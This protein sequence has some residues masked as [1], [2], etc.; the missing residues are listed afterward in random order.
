MLIRRASDIPSAEDIGL[1]GSKYV[2]FHQWHM[3]VCGGV[4]QNGRT[5]TLHDAIKR[6]WGIDC[7]DLSMK[8]EV[9][10][11]LRHL[12]VKIEERGF[13]LVE[14]DESAG[15]KSRHLSADFGAY[16]TRGARYHDNPSLDAFAYPFKFKPHWLPSQQIFY[17]N[18]SDLFAQVRVLE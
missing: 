1:Y 14:T 12:P 17:S 5:I 16:R 18:I 2:L 15:T 7:A 9:G 6:L 10:K 3:F 4:V 8:S 11:E 13:C